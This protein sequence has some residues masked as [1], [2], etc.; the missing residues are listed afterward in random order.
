[1]S[2]IDDLPWGGWSLDRHT[3]EELAAHLH[4]TQPRTV[5][6]CG[7]GLS[8]VLLAEYASAT[9][10]N[11]ISLEHSA[12][13]ASRT[14]RDLAGRDLLD[15]VDVRQAPLMDLATPAGVL[16]WY[17]VHVTESLDFVLVDGPPGKIGRAGALFGL[18]PHLTD[19]AWEI[20]LDD[21]DRDGERAAV[22]LWRSHYIFLDDHVPTPKGLARL[23]NAAVPAVRPWIDASDVT[24][25]LLTGGRPDLLAATVESCLS[26]APGLLETAHV[27]VLHNGADEDTA[28]LLDGW[29]SWIDHRTTVAERMPV[30]V[31]SSALLAF[32][33]PRPY[34]LHLEDDWQVATTDTTWLD[35]ARETLADPRIGQVRLRH[36]GDTVMRTHMVTRKPIWWTPGAV[37]GTLVGTAHY[38]LNPS[39]MRSQDTPSVW[40]A[41]GERAAARRFYNQSWLTGQMEPGVFRH[42]GDGASLR[43][44]ER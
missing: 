41:S 2:T 26:H 10:A 33:A 3:A 9:G 1:M 15:Y 31:A 30:D 13:Y 12:E 28:I 22:D 37:D 19:G 29:Q 34:T 25:T 35:R 27:A 32:P 21:A 40:P 18:M 43:L 23:R 11:V 39:L 38:T 5:L 4:R 24:V 6:E 42:L 17:G 14:R 20:W 16:P 36:R 44:G 7:S 8:T